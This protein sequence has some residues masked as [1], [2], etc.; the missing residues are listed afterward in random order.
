MFNNIILN[1]AIGMVFLYLLYSLLV[2]IVG[3]MIS[4]WLSLRARTLKKAITRMLIDEN[5]EKQDFKFGELKQ[6]LFN[7]LKYLKEFFRKKPKESENNFLDRFYNAPSI[8][9]TS[10]GA[11]KITTFQSKNPSYITNENF[12][13]TIIHLFR[14]KGNGQ[15]D[16]DK[17]DFCLKF[18]TL[19]IQPQT[20]SYLTNLFTDSGKD[21]N[22]FAQK[23]NNWFQE[24]MDR[25]KGWYK[26]K[27]NLISF[28]LGFVI[29]VSFN[30]DSIKIVRLLAKDENARDQLVSLGI[31]ASKD[32]LK[33]KPYINAMGDSVTSQSMID[34]AY[35]NISSDI[36]N[37][38]YVL[39]LGWDFSNL[40]CIDSTC[41]IVLSGFLKDTILKQIF[42][43][44]D[45]IKLV[46]KNLAADAGDNDSL[47]VIISKCKKRRQNY[48]NVLN[49]SL[50]TGFISVSYII[51]SNGKW[52]VFGEKKSGWFAKLS[53]ILDQSLPWKESFWG[54]LITALMLSLGAPFW[55]DLLKKLVALRGAG[56]N[57]DEK[58]K[59]KEN[60]GNV[61]NHSQILSKHVTTTETPVDTALRIYGDD[62]KKEKGVLNVAKG[63]Y[64]NS[65]GETEKCLQVN[66][67]NEET[68]IRIQTKYSELRIDENNFV[69]LNVLITGKPVL[70]ASNL[71]EF[72][73]PEIA[74]ANQTQI[75]G[76]GTI[77]CVASDLY[78]NHKY[79]LS[80]FHVMNGS[81]NWYSV[82]NN[83]NIINSKKGTIS[84]E[85]TGYL[86]EKLDVAKALISL[87]TAKEYSKFNNPSKTKI[88]TEDD[89]YKTD[90]KISSAASGDVKGI[91]VHNSWKD[92]FEYEIS[93]TNYL[94][95]QLI[96]LIAIS[97]VSNDGKL[98]TITQKGDSGSLVTDTDGN[99]VGIVVAGDNSHTFAVKM[100][101]VLSSLSLKL[102]SIV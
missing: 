50:K 74:I 95:H 59:D 30:V 1:V 49:D 77:C 17:V 56:V 37:A 83:K 72:K 78:S 63:Y 65:D 44:N 88:V 34:S 58:P 39:G 66:V 100:D 53:F 84:I 32:S 60:K 91:I 3:E 93:D 43:L 26:R 15:T 67:D 57:P 14:N 38:N 80:C 101:T 5:P 47:K 2:T 96:D 36:K 69:H 52:R 22:L 10:E 7:A 86:N 94:K 8:K 82:D 75:N 92:E 98:N 11:K 31:A 35:K 51:S 68:K 28:I 19:R 13:Q 97:N 87:D 33:F 41:P 85:Y 42:C 40:T 16:S 24:T 12:A 76:W 23:L 9:Y 48:I 29:A 79:L 21:I 102:E 27:T 45:T 54:F 89:I 18:N 62:I 20:L 55:F 46:E 73:S 70:L 90:V 99:A 4:S 71:S 81:R 25:T 64:K 6:Y 61:I